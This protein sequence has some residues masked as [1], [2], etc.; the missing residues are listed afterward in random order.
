[1]NGKQI[2]NE[3]EIK[4]FLKRLNKLETLKEQQDFSFFNYPTTR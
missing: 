1:M 2:R 3:Y 4:I